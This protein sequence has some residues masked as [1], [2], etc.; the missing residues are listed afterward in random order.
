MGASL[1]LL[2]SDIEAI[3]ILIVGFSALSA[4]GIAAGLASHWFGG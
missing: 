2:W 3:E 1:K 4:T